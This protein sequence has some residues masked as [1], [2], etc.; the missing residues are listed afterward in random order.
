MRVARKDQE[1]KPPEV[2]VVEIVR[3]RK[4]QRL[5]W[6]ESPGGRG[7]RSWY[8][9]VFHRDILRLFILLLARHNTFLL[10]QDVCYSFS[11]IRCA[12]Y[13]SY[14]TFFPL[15]HSYH[16]PGSL[17]NHPTSNTWHSLYPSIKAFIHLPKSHKCPLPLM[18]ALSL[19]D[20]VLPKLAR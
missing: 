7:S 8:K 20:C 13:W 5:A 18:P 6:P 12:R 4:N 19:S 15:P 14:G 16:A 17:R 2:R 1:N 9:N 11:Q 3:A 10:V